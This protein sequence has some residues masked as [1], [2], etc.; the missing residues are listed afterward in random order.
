M[1]NNAI[2]WNVNLFSGNLAGRSTMPPPPTTVHKPRI[3]LGLKYSTEHKLLS[4]VV[5]KARNLHETPHTTLPNPYVKI[6]TIERGVG[7]FYK[8]LDNKRKT[9]TL[10]NSVHP[11]FEE[12][13]DYFVPSVSDLKLRRLEISVC[14]DGGVLGRNVVLAHCIVSLRP[15][16][17]AIMGNAAAAAAAD[18][19]YLGES[20]TADVTEWYTLTPPKPTP[21][22]PDSV[23]MST[24]GAG[25]TPKLKRRSKSFA[26]AHLPTGTGTAKEV[27]YDSKRSL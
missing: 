2:I 26:N 12:T 9:K 21:P 11:V 27:Q 6:Y 15:L 1:S 18:K 5:H 19:K 17:D 23:S 7:L 24:T 25:T 13:L 3:Q 8:R 22:A 20:C 10:K 4:I 14:S 16:H